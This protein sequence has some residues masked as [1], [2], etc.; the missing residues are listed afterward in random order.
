[1]NA[2]LFGNLRTA[3]LST[4]F[5]PQLFYILVTVVCVLI[6]LCVSYAISL[7]IKSRK[8]YTSVVTIT[9]P[10]KIQE[11]LT[12]AMTKRSKF[13]ILFET[14]SKKEA[15]HCSL[16]DIRDNQLI[17]DTPFT[18]TGNAN[19]KDKNVSCYFHI[20]SKNNF[21]IFYNFSSQ[22]V[23]QRHQQG[24]LMQL[25][26]AVPESISLGQKRNFLR[27]QAPAATTPLSEVSI[28]RL[29]PAQFN[30]D[31]LQTNVKAWGESLL[32]PQN[33]TIWA[34]N[35]S[36]GGLRLVIQ[37]GKKYEQALKAVSAL[38]IY[39]SVKKHGEENSLRYMTNCKIRSFYMNSETGFLHLGLQFSHQAKQSEK[40]EQ[41]TWEEIEPE[42]GIE[43]IGNWAFLF[44]IYEHRSNNALKYR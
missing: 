37:N 39:F 11:L 41:V 36:Q 15:I 33:D 44:H 19:L 43:S 13:E 27:V 22:T 24:Q 17:L 6:L 32:S 26:V 29:W 40:P 5:S 12:Q 23:S 18:M 34:E 31:K 14:S 3:F 16:M 30:R 28:I 4:G 25:G 10:K 20:P 1:M 42:T 2:Y 38:F 7:L 8:R 35:I 21:A 9:E